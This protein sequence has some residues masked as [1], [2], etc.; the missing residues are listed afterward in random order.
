MQLVLSRLEEDGGGVV[1]V[2]GSFES[3]VE[4]EAGSGVASLP[5]REVVDTSL[6]VHIDKPLVGIGK[7]NHW[8]SQYE[9]NEGSNTHHRIKPENC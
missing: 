1:V 5:A 2:L 9:D 4:G 8:Q 6:A 7:S 3:Q